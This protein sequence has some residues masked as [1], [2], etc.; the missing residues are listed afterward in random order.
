MLHL[1][2]VPSLDDGK[3]ESFLDAKLYESF[4]NFLQKN[5]REL[6][7]AALL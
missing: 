3:Y 2:S 7:P 4:F 1:S 6:I 5:V